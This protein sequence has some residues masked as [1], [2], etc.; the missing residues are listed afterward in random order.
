MSKEAGKTFSA[1]AG[2]K[3]KTTLPG[4]SC[5]ECYEDW[6]GTATCKSRRRRD[7]ILQSCGRYVVG[8]LFLHPRSGWTRVVIYSGRHSCASSP[9]FYLEVFE[10]PAFRRL[11]CLVIIDLVWRRHPQSGDERYR[12]D[13]DN[14]PRQNSMTLPVK[15]HPYSGCSQCSRLR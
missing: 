3:L 15:G 10:Q 5:A 7:L 8:T 2:T 1:T 12:T 9:I 11:T 4:T 14:N 13:A 6:I